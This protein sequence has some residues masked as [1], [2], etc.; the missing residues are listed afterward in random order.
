M[1]EVVQ[2]D[3]P[4]PL[5]VDTQREANAGE[6][7]GNA[8]LQRLLVTG[9]LRRLR[10]LQVTQEVLSGRDVCWPFTTLTIYFA[11]LTDPFG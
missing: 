5:R 10:L 4:V 3:L 2:V 11:L 7:A 6:F 8:S 1:E 9:V